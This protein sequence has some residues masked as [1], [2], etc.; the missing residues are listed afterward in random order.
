MNFSVASRGELNPA[1]FAIS[2][3]QPE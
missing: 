1:D 3:S 2:I